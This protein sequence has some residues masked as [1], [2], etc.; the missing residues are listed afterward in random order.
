MDPDYDSIWLAAK[1]GDLDAV[2][3]FAEEGEPLDEIDE[4]DI[5]EEDSC[6]LGKLFLTASKST[7]GYTPLYWAC[8]GNHTEVADFLLENGAKDPTCACF[9]VAKDSELIEVLKSY[10]LKSGN[11]VDIEDMTEEEREKHIQLQ[12]RRAEM[13]RTHETNENDDYD[14]EPVGREPM[15]K[16]SRSRLGRIGA[17]VKKVAKKAKKAVSKKKSNKLEEE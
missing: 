7:A 12:K 3:Y 8:L 2:E 6:W 16:N 11:V 9:D 5:D 14:D 13:S 10:G 17:K 1:R 4:R 15:R